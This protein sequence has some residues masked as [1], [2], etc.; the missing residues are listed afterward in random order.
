MAAK[1]EVASSMTGMTNSASLKIQADCGSLNIQALQRSR[2]AE[3]EG[4][5]LRFERAEATALKVQAQWCSRSA[6]E[7]ADASAFSYVFVF[8]LSLSPAGPPFWTSDRASGAMRC[9]NLP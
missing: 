9:A 3:E 8:P 1:E 5:F 6:K 7:R 2:A 4:T